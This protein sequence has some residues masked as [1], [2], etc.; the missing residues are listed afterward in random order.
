MTTPASSSARPTLDGIE[1]ALFQSR[2]QAI[3]DEMGAVLRRSAFSP[4]IK[5]RLDFSCAVFAPNGE[6]FGQAAH[7]PVHLGSMAYAMG[8]V[9][10]RFEW[11]PGDVVLLNDPYL[12]GT[13]LP[14]VT[15]I[16]PA[17]VDGRVV[18]FAA[19][20]A[21][22][23]N[24]G[25]DR[26]G[27]MPVADRL[28]QEG[29]LIPPVLAL[30]AGALTADCKRVLDAIARR[31]H[32]GDEEFRSD[33]RLG[34]FWA[35]LSSARVGV[36]RLEA[37]AREAQFAAGIVAVN[38][39][40]ERLARAALAGVPRGTW[41]FADA[42]DDDGFGSGP[43]RIHVAVTVDDD[44]VVAD[45]SASAAQVRGNVNC[46]RSVLAA[47]AYYVFRCLMPAETPAAAGAFRPIRLVSRRG[48]VVDAEA[49]AAV[50]AG[51]V[52]TSQRIVDVLLG[53]LAQALPD[54]VPAA[55]QGTMN[56]IAMGSRAGA[57]PW[58]YY[59]TLGGGTG[60]SALGAGISAVHSHMTNTL[61]TPIESLELHYPL[62]VVRYEIRRRS[63]GEG[64]ERGGDGIVRELEFRA[65]ADVTLLT[66]R[67][68]IAPWGL[69][70]GSAGAPGINLL[71][72]RIVPGKAE[73][74][75]RRGDRLRIET[76]GGGGYGALS[77]AR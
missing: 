75:V 4:N 3:C 54:L 12:G 66:E 36:A 59:E 48:T 1:L 31:T 24:I 63:G 41:Q 17:F 71:N 56:N 35:Q 13:H 9:V 22:H 50:A 26:P 49:P 37:L 2:V 25:A 11:Q 5:D 7:I 46:P 60:A 43:V 16:G 65:D 72:G 64:R 44:G 69:D 42:L 21:H 29:I 8:G 23:A 67:R 45:F 33:E 68:S 30:R 62:T 53:A 40:A 61:N 47:G 38:D 18:A 39:Y 55:S 34:D 70:G 76:P 6:L 74:A 10:A 27:S 52:E 77:G 28:E 32:D 14:D 51:N 58:D 57:T 19:C 73:L 15:A 20:R